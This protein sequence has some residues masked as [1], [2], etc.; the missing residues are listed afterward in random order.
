MPLC[1]ESA[2]VASLLSNQQDALLTYVAHL[3]WDAYWQAWDPHVVLVNSVYPAGAVLAD[4]LGLPKV[5]LCVLGP[6]SSFLYLSAGLSASAS[7]MPIA[8]YWK[9]TPLVSSSLMMLI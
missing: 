2:G 9:P 3:T 1:K 8:P 4:M 5:A 7:L 6:V